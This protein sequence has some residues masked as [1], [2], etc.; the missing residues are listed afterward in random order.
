MR[1]VIHQP[2][3]FPW[4]G[5]MDKMAKCEKYI[6]A[7]SMQLTKGSNMYRNKF[8][9]NTGKEIFLTICFEKDNCL[10]IPYKE[11]LLNND[12]DWKQDHIN[13]I[14]NNYRKSCFFDEVWNYISFIFEK[15]YKFL[16]EITLDS[17]VAI[18]NMLDIST[19][20]ILQ[21][22]LNYD[23]SAKNNELL[24]SICKAVEA[25]EYLSGNGARKYMDLDLFSENDIKVEYQQFTHPI[26]NQLNSNSFIP[27]LSSLDIL[28]NYG[29][30]KT[31]KI[32]WE[33]V[34]S[35]NEFNN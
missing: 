3:Y 17:I 32:F 1:I 25:N 19:E 21:S 22:S 20:V 2:H 11:V 34:K 16:Y 9:S 5:Y 31:R 6:L 15:E 29:I 8:L 7:D 28:F 35:K 27:N 23:S 18:K 26:Y 30:E 33:N 4:L 13:F 10:N 24:I 14:N 12:I